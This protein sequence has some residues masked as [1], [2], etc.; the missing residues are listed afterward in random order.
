MSTA[1]SVRWDVGALRFPV[2]SAPALANFRSLD[3]AADILCDLFA[4]AITAELNEHWSAVMIGTPLAGTSAVQSKF[5]ELDDEENI[6]Q[7]KVA[8]PM[9]SVARSED[10]QTIQQVTLDERYLVSKWEVDWVLGTLEIAD[11]YKVGP[12]LEAAG[13]VCLAVVEEGGHKAYSAYVSNGYTMVQPVFQQCGFDSVRV[14]EFR[15]GGAKFSD[16][17]PKYWAMTLML[18]TTELIQM[19]ERG[20]TFTGATVKLGTGGAAGIVENLVVGDTSITVEDG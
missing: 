6:R 7:A 4:A 3:P 16:N 8:F 10:P 2:P 9:L 17:S 15:C 19:G 12:I 1:N 14:T 13:K 5:R 11:V 18:E 20:G